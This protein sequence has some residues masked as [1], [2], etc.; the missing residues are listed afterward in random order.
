MRLT[1]TVLLVLAAACARPPAPP[2]GLTRIELYVQM[3][4]QQWSAFSTFRPDGW[5]EGGHISAGFVHLDST[6]IAG[7][8][9]RAIWEA[10]L[11]VALEP[12]DT[13]GPT[14]SGSATILT[15]VRTDSVQVRVWWPDSSRHPDPRVRALADHLL[16][17]RAGRW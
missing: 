4:A 8:S 5:V 14:A 3:P 1:P 7:D 2:P 13:A 16:A 10:A 17:N 9:V 11:P 6:R 12:P 15:L